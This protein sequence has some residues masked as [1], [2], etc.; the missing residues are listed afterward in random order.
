MTNPRKNILYN[1]LPNIGKF[2]QVTQALIQGG[3]D[4]NA[5][6]K[7][8]QTPLIYSCIEQH[9]AVAKLLLQV[10]EPH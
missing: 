4:V 7:I 10:S 5:T 1:L 3:A 2:E 8:G 9:V 6:N